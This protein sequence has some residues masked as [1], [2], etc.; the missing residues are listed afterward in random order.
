MERN[1]K[2]S[3]T[4]IPPLRCS[5]QIQ[6]SVVLYVRLVVLAC[7]LCFPPMDSC[8][9]AAHII[10][11]RTSLQRISGKLLYLSIDHLLQQMQ[12]TPQKPVPVCL[13]ACLHVLLCLL[14]GGGVVVVVVVVGGANGGEG[15]E[16]RMQESINP[17]HLV[18][19]F[20]ITIVVIKGK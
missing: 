5:T 18:L 8:N 16:G 19:C 11:K 10:S 9:G 14:G 20:I 17:K 3:N 6:C 12:Q 1:R 4:K 2:A 15:D 13:L 7:W